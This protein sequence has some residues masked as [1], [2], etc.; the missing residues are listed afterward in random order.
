MLRHLLNIF[1]FALMCVCLA[2]CSD[3]HEEMA[4]EE[5]APQTVML[6]L[7]VSAKA[8][9]ATAAD[10]A[11]VPQSLMLW[12]FGNGK[13]EPLFF[14]TYTQVDWQEVNAQV[15]EE[16]I[17]YRTYLKEKVEL[18]SYD[19]YSELRVHVV[20]NYDAVSNMTLGATS[21]EADIQAATF[22]LK[23]DDASLAYKDNGQLMYGMNKITSLRID[24]YHDVSVTVR[25]CVAKLELYF[26]Q[27]N[28]NLDL[29]VNSVTLAN[30]PP[31]GYVV[32]D[33]T[34]VESLENTTASVPMFAA[35]SADGWSVGGV[36][37]P[38][39]V[40]YGDF[41]TKYEEGVTFRQLPL[42]R[43][44]LLERK[45][46]AWIPPTNNDEVYDNGIDSYVLTVNYT[47]TAYDETAKKMQTMTL[48]K[49][50]YMSKIE[51][52]TRYRIFLRAAGNQLVEVN[53]VVV[54]WNKGRG[55]Q[56]ID[57]S[58]GLDYDPDEFTPNKP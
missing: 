15:G 55:E 46:A 6:N 18:N 19:N 20:A 39:S 21:T 7:D 24:S 14:K 9:M 3:S 38:P 40:L 11:D 2:A 51:R 36:V 8:L 45:G 30:L 32:P 56:N 49:I 5:N 23:T 16:Y 28:P 33:W 53:T 34:K 43:P 10:G 52:N 13:T 25:R 26:T 47:K 27:T 42:A 31:L 57:V 22:T 35:E 50:V 37:L 58:P 4:G 54:P 44:Y 17:D 1:G 41:S 12:V 29:K 48:D